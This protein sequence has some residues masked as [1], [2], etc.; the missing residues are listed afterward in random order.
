MKTTLP[1]KIPIVK[2]PQIYLAGIVLLFISSSSFA[3]VI[4]TV[5][6][7][8]VF[9][10]VKAEAAITVKGTVTD[11]VN[12]QTLIGVSIKI[13]GTKIGTVTD[14]NGNFSIRADDNATLVFTYLGYEPIEVAVNGRTSLN[15]KM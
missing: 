2:K 4:N 3:T 13:K 10:Q 15:V 9:T 6:N 7:K 14:V 12:G 11:G 1:I 5:S 8:T